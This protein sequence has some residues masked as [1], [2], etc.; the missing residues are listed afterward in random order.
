MY[1]SAGV[2]RRGGRFYEQKDKASWDYFQDE[3]SFAD[4]RNR[5][6]ERDLINNEAET[7]QMFKKDN[8]PEMAHR[9]FYCFLKIQLT[10]NIYKPILIF[11][12]KS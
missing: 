2:R 6:N 8:Y 12:K 3:A 11:N 7:M 10:K 5:N 9:L 4:S 1:F